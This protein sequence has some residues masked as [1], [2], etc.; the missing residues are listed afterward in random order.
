MKISPREQ[1]N[2]APETKRIRKILEGSEI[3][4][5]FKRTN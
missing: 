5:K 2:S 4:L 1:T 3:A